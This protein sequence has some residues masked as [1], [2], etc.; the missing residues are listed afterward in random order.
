MNLNSHNGELHERLLKYLDDDLVPDEKTR[1][2]ELLIE[3]ADAREILRELALQAVV[4][5]DSERATTQTQAE[6]RRVENYRGVDDQEV[7]P[8]WPRNRVILP[9]ALAATSIC[10]CLALVWHAVLPGQVARD[11]SGLANADDLR[12]AE[13]RFAANADLVA[14]SSSGNASEKSFDE[15]ARLSRGFYRLRRGFVELEFFGGV[16][17]AV[18]SP[19]EL[20]LISQR[21]A[22]LLSGRVT[23]EAGDDDTTFVL[24]TPVGEVLDIGTRYGVY[25]ADD[26]ATETHVFEGQVDIHPTAS[27]ESVRRV[28]AASA[29]RVTKEGAVATV[30]PIESAFPQPSRQIRNLLLHGGFEPATELHV[31]DVVEVG[32]WWGDV[33]RIV[34][35]DQSVRPFAGEGMLLFQSTGKNPEKAAPTAASQLSQ[36]IDL[37]PYEAAIADGRGRAV[38]SCRFNRVVGNELTDSQ[39]SI[40]L[41]SF[42]AT[43]Q[44]AKQRMK[45]Q[46]DAPRSRVSY[47][48]LSD[49]NPQ[50][51]ER[52]EAVL[53]LPTDARYLLVTILAFENVSN[54][55]GATSE[56]DGHFAD[57]LQ[58]HLVIDPAPGA[59][60]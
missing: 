50:S 55:V 43:P 29:V 35:T 7:P 19:A 44:E 4:I 1:V 5:A 14:S 42:D 53:T 40:H 25:V 45:S 28:N 59:G 10:V 54:D 52:A 26:G 30:Q 49:S 37:T 39:F 46:P 11:P 34:R 3:D 27:R 31:A 36:W 38:V 6:L 20:E 12:L 58:F 2:E 18:E 9:W 15:D 32:S 16:V 17:L 57:D 60:Q 23:V 48:L 21:E 41:E 47:Q 56:F 33:C 51:W 22:R 8:R 24:H 13:I